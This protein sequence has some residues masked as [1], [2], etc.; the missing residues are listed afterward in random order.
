MV[1]FKFLD[2]PRQTSLLLSGITPLKFV[3]HGAETNR[4][5]KTYLQSRKIKKTNGFIS[6]KI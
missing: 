4:L 6:T 3:E 5:I 1:V 2:S